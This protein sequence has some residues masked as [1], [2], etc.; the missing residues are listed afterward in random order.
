MAAGVV[1]DA[2]VEAVS[3]AAGAD[4]AVVGAA[5]GAEAMAVRARRGQV[6]HQGPPTRAL[7][8]PAEGAPH[9]PVEDRVRRSEIALQGIGRGAA[10][11]VA[12]GPVAVG[13]R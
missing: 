4:A 3:A 1:V 10:G 13:R 6:L 9:V 11:P 12:V 2:A 8:D 5:P 7:A